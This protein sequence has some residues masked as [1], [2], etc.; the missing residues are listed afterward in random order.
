MIFRILL[1]L[2]LFLSSCTT[3]EK[4]EPVG[5][6]DRRP[7]WSYIKPGMAARDV[8]LYLGQPNSVYIG[9]MFIEWKYSDSGCLTF[10]TDDM[11]LISVVR[12]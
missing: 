8:I 3:Y 12:P 4:Y 2:C 10:N 5:I 1:I 6:E 11:T 9:M 7:G